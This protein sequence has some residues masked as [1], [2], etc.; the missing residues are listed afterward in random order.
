MPQP[1]QG[2]LDKL[3]MGAVYGLILV[4]NAGRGSKE[5]VRMKNLLTY[6]Q[7]CSK[8]KRRKTVGAKPPKGGDAKLKGLN[9]EL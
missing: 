7:K 2:N 1:G 3:P 6:Y 4:G 5:G 9:H 8:M